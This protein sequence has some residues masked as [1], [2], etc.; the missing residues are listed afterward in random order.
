MQISHKLNHNQAPQYNHT[1]V[2]LKQT[3]QR[4]NVQCFMFHIE[5]QLRFSS[6]GNKRLVLTSLGNFT[7]ADINASQRERHH[8]TEQPGRPEGGDLSPAGDTRA[9]G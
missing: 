5:N 9:A 2:A 6:G 8:G 4:E 7:G 1:A 3:Q